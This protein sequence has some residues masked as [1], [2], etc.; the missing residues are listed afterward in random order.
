M[1]LAER[2]EL[3]CA[4]GSA[5]GELCPAAC[6][7]AA[8]QQTAQSAVCEQL[9]ERFDLAPFAA[10]AGAREDADSA[11]SDAQQAAASAPQHL[12]AAADAGT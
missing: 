8:D 7:S 2:D 6:A 12:T 9:V 1:Q 4:E 5:G 11:G 3:V 10:R